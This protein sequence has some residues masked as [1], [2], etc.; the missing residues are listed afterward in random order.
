MTSL[1]YWD[2]SPALDPSTP[3]WPG[4]TPFQQ[5]WAARLDEQCPVNVGR[6]TLSPHTGAHVDGPLHYRADGLPIANKLEAGKRPRSSMAPTLV[7]DRQGRL[8]AV[9]GSPGGSQIPN[10]VAQALLGLLE[11]GLTPAQIVSQPRLGSRNG[12]TEVERGRMAKDVIDGLRTRGHMLREMDMTSGIALVV[13]SG[14]G[15]IGAADPRREG[16][17]GGE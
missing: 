17:A 7:F 14:K 8:Y 2:I 16:R 1:R 9:L 3:T 11:G 4:D 12:P 10:Y 5:E 13:R 15:W 6:I